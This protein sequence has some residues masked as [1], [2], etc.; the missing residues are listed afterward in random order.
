MVGVDWHS[1]V[2]G[3]HWVTCCGRCWR[4]FG[5]VVVGQ[6]KEETSHLVTSSVSIIRISGTAPSHHA[7]LPNAD[8]A[9]AR[10]I[11]SVLTV[12]DDEQP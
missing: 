10:V 11:F 3:C 1:M 4:L 5:V 9:L 8:T 6:K 12:C 2:M 7:P